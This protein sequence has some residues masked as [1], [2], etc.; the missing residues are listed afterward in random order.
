MTE[1]LRIQAG[2]RRQ[3]R[4]ARLFGANPLLPDARSWYR[5]ALGELHVALLLKRLPAEWTLLHTLDPDSAAQHLLIGPAGAYTIGTKNHSGQRIWV[6]ENT[7]LVNGHRTNHLRDA[8]YEASRT[9]RHMS[10]WADEGCEVTPVIA[11]VDPGSLAFARN[12][13]RDVLVVSSSQLERTLLRRKP[14]LADAAIP[15][16]IA[17]AEHGGSW[18]SAARVLDDTLRHEA[19]FARLRESVDSAARRR[20]AWL[21]GSVAAGAAA[22]AAFTFIYSS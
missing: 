20:F 5:G 8:R 10:S 13:P 12:R 14:R 4:I 2:A 18:T 7:L 3:S 22:L 15:P 17:A 21:L 16:L 9:T 1:C 11:V 6:D 19:R